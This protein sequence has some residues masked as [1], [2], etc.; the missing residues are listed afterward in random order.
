MADINYGEYTWKDCKFDPNEHPDYPELRTTSLSTFWSTVEKILG[1]TITINGDYS[2]KT[3]SVNGNPYIS[4]ITVGDS[5]L[6]ITCVPNNMSEA[7]K[8]NWYLKVQSDDEEIEH[9]STDDALTVTC[10]SNGPKTITEI[11]LGEKT[12]HKV[13]NSYRWNSDLVSDWKSITLDRG[14]FNEGYLSG[15]W[16]VNEKDITIEN[17][18]S[19]TGTY[20][21]QVAS[22]FKIS[23]STVNDATRRLQVI[24][25]NGEVIFSQQHGTEH[26]V[27]LD[28]GTFIASVGF[29]C[30]E[31]E[32]YWPW[33]CKLETKL[34]PDVSSV[35]IDQHTGHSK[36]KRYSIPKFYTD[37]RSISGYGW[38]RDAKP[39]EILDNTRGYQTAD[40]ISPFNTN[41]P[42]KMLFT[43]QFFE[44]QYNILLNEWATPITNNMSSFPSHTITIQDDIVYIDQQEVYHL[45]KGDQLIQYEFM[46]LNSSDLS[47]DING[48]YGFSR[49]IKGEMNPATYYHFDTTEWKWNEIPCTNPT[50]SLSISY[51]WSNNSP[52][53]ST[54]L[55]FDSADKKIP[56]QY[57]YTGKLADVQYQL[58]WGD[59]L[60]SQEQT[61]IQESIQYTNAQWQCKYIGQETTRQKY[62]YLVDWNAFMFDDTEGQIAIEIDHIP[63]FWLTG[64]PVYQTNIEQNLQLSEWVLKEE[65]IENFSASGYK[66]KTL[67]HKDITLSDYASDSNITTRYPWPWC[68][69][70]DIPLISGGCLEKNDRGTYDE[71]LYV[72]C[73]AGASFS[74]LTSSHQGRLRLLV[75]WHFVRL[76]ETQ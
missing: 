43:E 5:D 16:G 24:T 47:N 39:D 68:F 65:V 54:Y 12:A 38:Y 56:I 1:C 71:V 10:K 34:T 70:N 76:E 32:S 28:G 2:I 44:N 40:N 15:L 18:G 36:L 73:Q 63:Y 23:I 33:G 11:N 17:K 19:Y 46:P 13:Y 58:L 61:W 69:G 42:T 7:E 51:S 74:Q 31:N 25:R 53:T 52:H 26:V 49:N 59:P 50:D 37:N 20:G 64:V 8:D 29:G 4:A 57:K 45:Q 14:N 60:S 9:Q 62:E 3:S 66:T 41:K 55:W 30:V 75:V 72:Y 48:V 22:G 35:R 67:H 6:R 27:M 21:W